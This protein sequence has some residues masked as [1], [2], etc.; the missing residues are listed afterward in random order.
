MPADTSSL[1]SH[2]QTMAPAASLPNWMVKLL[3]EIGYSVKGTIRN[4][5]DPKNSHLRELEGASERLTLCKAD[6]LDYESLRE[7]ISGCQGVFYTASPV[8]DD[9]VRYSL[10]L[11]F[12]F[13]FNFG[14]SVWMLRNL[15][16][17]VFAA[18]RISSRCC[19]PAP[20]RC[21]SH[22]SGT[23]LLLRPQ[24]HSDEGIEV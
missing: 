14:S 7:A 18:L 15:L 24:L 6:L 1:P 17:P 22:C 4:P 23:A 11:C 5:D 3:L 19:P 21:F 9:P 8:N 20:R 13:H 12:S 2:D 10:P 16:F